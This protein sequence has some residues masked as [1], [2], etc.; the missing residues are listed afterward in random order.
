MITLTTVRQGRD[1]TWLAISF[2]ERS[3][4]YVSNLSYAVR[5]VSNQFCLDY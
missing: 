2:A 1:A 3:I 5:E 4:T